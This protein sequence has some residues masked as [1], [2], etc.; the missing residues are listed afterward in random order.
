MAGVGHFQRNTNKISCTNAEM[1]AGELEERF[2]VPQRRVTQV[3]V[4]GK[5]VAHAAKNCL[6]SVTAFKVP[7]KKKFLFSYFKVLIKK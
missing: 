6:Y 5:D 3:T 1:V 7:M 4:E 2:F